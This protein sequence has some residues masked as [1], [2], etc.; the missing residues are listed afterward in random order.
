MCFKVY[1][2]NLHCSDFLLHY[3]ALKEQGK[4]VKIIQIKNWLKKPPQHSCKIYIVEK[5]FL[6][7]RV[8]DGKE[9]TRHLPSSRASY[10]KRKGRREEGGR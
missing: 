5:V 8:Q 9:Q 4:K 3:T 10:P 6:G 1:F 2:L 7:N